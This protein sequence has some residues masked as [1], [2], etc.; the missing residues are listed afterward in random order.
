VPTRFA[1]Q[2]TV[3]TLSPLDLS[4]LG[5]F[6]KRR[7]F[8]EFEQSGNDASSLSCRCQVGPA[9][10][11]HPLPHAGRPQSRRH[12]ASQHPITTRRSSSIIEMP[13]KAP[14]SPALIPLLESL[15][16]PSSAINGLGYKSPAVTHQHLHPEQPGPL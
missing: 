1:P 13:I 3:H 2:A 11:F 7:L 12:L 4:T 14:Y 5:V 6:A 10:Q 16:T 8:F 9:R 15:L